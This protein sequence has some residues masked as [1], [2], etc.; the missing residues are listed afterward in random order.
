MQEVHRPAIDVGR[1]LGIPVEDLLPRCPVE[2]LLPP[3]QKVT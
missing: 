3:L 2:A 1:E